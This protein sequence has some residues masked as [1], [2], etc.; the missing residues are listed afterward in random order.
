MSFMSATIQCWRH[1][2]K[3]IAKAAYLEGNEE[4]V[5]SVQTCPDCKKEAVDEGK[6]ARDSQHYYP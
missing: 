3:L 6:K 4:L 2:T 1:G 5:I